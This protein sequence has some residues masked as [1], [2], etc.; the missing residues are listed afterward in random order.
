VDSG[1]KRVD[2]AGKTRD[3]IVNSV[4]KVTDIMME[5]AAASKEQ[6][7][8]IDQVNTAVSQ[9]D[10]MTQQNAALV[11]EAAAAAKSMEEQTNALAQSVAIYKLAEDALAA[12][13]VTG[14]PVID[15]AVRTADHGA[16][17]TARKPSTPVAEPRKEVRKKVANG[18]SGDDWSEF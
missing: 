17:S 16:Q 8:G 1:S 3:E 9:M 14:N 15:R 13:N 10:K 4:K 18:R 6:S 5:I 12:L 2:S 7:G 11:E